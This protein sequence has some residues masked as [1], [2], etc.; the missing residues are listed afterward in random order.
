MSVSLLLL[1]LAPF[2]AAILLGMRRPPAGRYLAFAAALLLAMALGLAL[3]ILGFALRGVGTALVL[4]WVPALGLDGNLH[5]DVDGAAFALAIL[6]FGL[7][8]AW[9][10]RRAPAVAGRPSPL[11]LALIL[12]GVAQLAVL[13][14]NLLVAIAV[15]ELA[16][17]LGYCLERGAAPAGGAGPCLALGALSAGTLF[18]LAGAL[19]VGDSTG[20]YRS[21]AIV[22]A[23]AT[24]GAQPL[25]PAAVGLLLAGAWTRS[26]AW[27]WGLSLRRSRANAF[28][29]GN[30][31]GTVLLL[32]G[33]CLAIRLLPALVGAVPGIAVA[34]GF[35]AIPLLLG[36]IAR[37]LGG[38][39]PP[40]RPALATAPEAGAGS[41]T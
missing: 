16:A 31:A 39:V 26:A 24:L 29:V 7:R 4:P 13:A 3:A 25:Y 18:L 6:V 9:L 5:G 2:A 14:D 33:L 34:A 35:L 32:T 40:G 21:G 28:G 41:E 27:P 19:L 15:S 8:A 10:L 1:A 37:L 17:V 22:V 23:T 36:S 12:V 11:A 30:A 38:S 20:T